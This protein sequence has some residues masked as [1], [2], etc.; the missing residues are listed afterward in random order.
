MAL[1]TVR[2]HKLYIELKPN[3]HINKTCNLGRKS[4]MHTT[5]GVAR[6]QRTAL[7]GMHVHPEA[8]S[9]IDNEN[10]SNVVRS[11]R[12]C[13]FRAITAIRNEF[14]IIIMQITTT[15]VSSNV[16]V[17]IDSPT[18]ELLPSNIGIVSYDPFVN[19]AYRQSH[20]C[21]CQSG[22]FA[23]KQMSKVKNCGMNNVR[24]CDDR[25]YLRRANF[26]ACLL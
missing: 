23:P 9:D 20:I 24:T 2:Q 7:M 6:E 22:S 26:S 3:H 8:R 11:S 10:M 15:F 5:P 25:R 12:S 1:A 19:N 4:T 14:N 13:G 17:C 16:I 18:V 21:L